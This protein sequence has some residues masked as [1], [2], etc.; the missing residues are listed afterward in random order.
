[1]VFTFGIAM[2]VQTMT[3]ASV[4][5]IVLTRKMLQL[6]PEWNFCLCE[7]T[8]HLRKATTFTVDATF[9]ALTFFGQSHGSS[10]SNLRTGGRSRTSNSA[11]I[12]KQ[13]FGYTMDV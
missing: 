11:Q 8:N 5:A 9:D 3:M 10:S 13:E 12:G 4:V 7:G 6:L 2:S 1:M